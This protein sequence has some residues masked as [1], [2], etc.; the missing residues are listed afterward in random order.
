[1]KRTVVLCVVLLGA[2]CADNASMI[3]IQGR[4]APD[5]IT[6]CGFKPGG[7]FLL[8]PGLLDVSAANPNFELVVYVK[9]NLADPKSTNPES[10]TSARVWR[11]FAAKVRVD[12]KSYTDAFGP[13]PPL[14]VTQLSNV[15]PLDG[16]AVQPAGGTS[17]LA[18]EAISGSLGTQLRTL[19]DPT[20]ITTVVLGITLEGRLSGDQSE[21]DTA[22]WFFPVK[23]CNGCLQ[24]PLC[25]SGQ[26]LK[27]T[28]CFS[29]HQDSAPI[30]AAP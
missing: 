16:Q 1:M 14:P 9:N 4:A 11:G 2:A 6:T 26:V 13:N 28:N 15:N 21:V 10:L 5:D 17:A 12:P 8:G 19:V 3:E 22:E 30:C 20:Q 18:V 27:G 24:A 29:S 23:L 7:E 25:P